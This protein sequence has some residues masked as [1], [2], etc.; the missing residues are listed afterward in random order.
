M[1]Q[2]LRRTSL[3][4]SL[5][6]KLRAALEIEHTAVVYLDS[7]LV[8]LGVGEFKQMCVQ[9][10]YSIDSVIQRALLPNLYN[11]KNV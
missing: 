1:R 6:I 11:P 4:F 9:Y 10:L 8:G 2:K 3:Y 5:F 7:W